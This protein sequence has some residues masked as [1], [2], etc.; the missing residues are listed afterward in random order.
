MDK[1]TWGNVQEIYTSGEGIYGIRARINLPSVFLAQG[2]DSAHYLDA[3]VAIFPGN[4]IKSSLVEAGPMFYGEYHQ[5]TPTSPH[6]PAPFAHRWSIGVNPSGGGFRGQP[7]QGERNVLYVGPKALMV[8]LTLLAKDQAEVKVNGKPFK[9]PNDFTFNKDGRGVESSTF[10][11]GFNVKACIGLNDWGGKGVQFADFSIEV[12]QVLRK[13]THGKLWGPPPDL[14]R[15]FLLRNTKTT[16]VGR[17][18]VVTYP[19]PGHEATPA[20]P[21]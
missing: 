1:N 19:R 3:Y 11:K 9:V 20:K 10:D 7:R 18:L 4:D 5:N 15:K 21:R 17:K 2:H 14:H 13:S 12:V 6:V 16:V 8:E